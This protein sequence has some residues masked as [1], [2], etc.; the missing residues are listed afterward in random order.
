M[1]DFRAL[2]MISHFSLSL[3][4]ALQALDGLIVMSMWYDFQPTEYSRRLTMETR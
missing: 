1:G 4:V 3:F 2:H